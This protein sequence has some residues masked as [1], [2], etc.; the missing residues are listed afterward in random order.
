MKNAIN[1]TSKL[2]CIICLLVMQSCTKDI[3]LPPVPTTP[4]NDLVE[5][6]TTEVD[7]ELIKKVK[8][9]NQALEKPEVFT[10]VDEMPEFP[11]GMERL[12]PFLGRHIK[13]PPRAHRRGIQGTVYVG[14]TI[15]EDGDVQDIHIKRGLPGGGAGCDEEA[16]RVTRLLPNWKPG[17][18]QGEAVRVA[19]TLPIKFKLD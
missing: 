9:E 5:T 8:T 11:G 12:R 6:E 16:L 1:L 3:P 14:F 4:K 15:M 19:Y 13:Y 10:I 7:N 18:H 17:K 2:L